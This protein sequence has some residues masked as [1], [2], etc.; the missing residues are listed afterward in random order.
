MPTILFLLGYRFFFY[1]N[2]G[3]EPPHIHVT[4]GDAAGKIW[5]TPEIDIAYMHGFNSKE[6]NQVQ[7]IVTENAGL[8]KLKWNEYF[9]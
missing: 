5:L 3:Q 8:F 6:I 2:E 4:K 1:S 7:G 9:S